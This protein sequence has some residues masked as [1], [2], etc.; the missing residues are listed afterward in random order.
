MK[1]EYINTDYATLLIH[2]CHI[3]STIIAD[4]GSNNIH[5]YDRSVTIF[6]GQRIIIL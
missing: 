3:I 5:L 2:L 6:E 4:I 1:Y